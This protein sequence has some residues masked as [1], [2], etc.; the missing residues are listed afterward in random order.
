MRAR[1]SYLAEMDGLEPAGGNVLVVATTNRP[2]AMDAALMRP[3]RLD[4]VLY[5]PPPVGS[6]WS[7]VENPGRFVALKDAWFQMVKVMN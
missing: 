1:L 2:A 5:V 4:L 3:G 7:V 6:E